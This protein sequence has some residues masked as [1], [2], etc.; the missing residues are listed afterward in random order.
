MIYP[1]KDSNLFSAPVLCCL[2]VVVLGLQNNN[3]RKLALHVHNI[4]LFDNVYYRHH[5]IAFLNE[6]ISK[7]DSF[8]AMMEKG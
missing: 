4:N 8:G 5:I 1:E 2:Y 7:P 3:E 6:N